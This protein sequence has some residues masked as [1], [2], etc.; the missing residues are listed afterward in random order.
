MEIKE[1][2]NVTCELQGY[3]EVAAEVAYRNS[4]I[5]LTET[6]TTTTTTDE[7]GTSTSEITIPRKAN[8]T[9]CQFQCGFSSEKVPNDKGIFR[10][11]IGYGN[12]KNYQGEPYSQQVE[13]TLKENDSK[14]FNIP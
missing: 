3:E 2:V 12:Q 13:F 11:F 4:I 14:T 5:T 9:Q 1:L 10:A 7:S 6:T 8:A